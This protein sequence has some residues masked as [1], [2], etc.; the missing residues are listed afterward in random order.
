M[1]QLDHC[2]CLL[3]FHPRSELEL[4]QGTVQHGDGVEENFKN[5]IEQKTNCLTSDRHG[6]CI[7]VHDTC[8]KPAVTESE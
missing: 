3:P 6:V 1:N 8:R 5:H 2:G 4:K 7:Y